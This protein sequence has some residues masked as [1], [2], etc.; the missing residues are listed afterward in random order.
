MKPKSPLYRVSR[1]TAGGWLVWENDRALA[2]CENEA[3]ARAVCQALN[4]QRAMLAWKLL[5]VVPPTGYYL[6]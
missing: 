4:L 5:R 6:N 2:F 1:C 3:G